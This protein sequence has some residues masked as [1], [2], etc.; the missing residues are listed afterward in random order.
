MLPEPTPE[1]REAWS[2]GISIFAGEAEARL[3]ALLQ[4]ACR[5]ALKPLYDY[6]ADLPDLEGKIAPFL[7]H[8]I[9]RRTM[10]RTTFDAGR[11]CP[12]QCSFSTII[13]WQGRKS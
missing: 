13:N 1:I 3:E 12:F 6:G 11:G 8:P 7:P 5:G 9:I 10:G 2:L 4:D